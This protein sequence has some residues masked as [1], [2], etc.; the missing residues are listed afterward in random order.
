[1]CSCADTLLHSF[2]MKATGDCS[3]TH[4]KANSILVTIR[5]ASLSNADAKKWQVISS[6][7]T[8]QIMRTCECNVKKT[9]FIFNKLQLVMI[10]SA[11]VKLMSFS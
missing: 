7:N 11:L 9:Y 1:M 10:H 8:Q 4:F 3:D 2:L 5:L 6:T